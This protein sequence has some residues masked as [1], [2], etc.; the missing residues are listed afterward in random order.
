MLSYGS[1]EKYYQPLD[2][3]Q[4][5]GEGTYG[6][7]FRVVSHDGQPY[8]CKKLDMSSVPPRYRPSKMD[9]LENLLLMKNDY[10]CRYHHIFYD[11]EQNRALLVMDYFDRCCLA[12]IIVYYHAKGRQIPEDTIWRV[13]SHML[14]AL[15]YYHTPFKAGAPKVNRIVH[16]DV[17]PANIFLAGDGRARIVDSAAYRMLDKVTVTSTIFGTLGYTPPEALAMDQ[18][19]DKSDIWSLG[20]CIYAMC[21]KKPYAYNEDPQK[22]YDEIIQQPPVD[23]T[24]FGYSEDLNKALSYMLVTNPS[25][26]FCANDLMSYPTVKSASGPADPTWGLSF[27]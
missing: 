27:D 13:L 25:Q 19:T 3:T 16:R 11:S 6:D 5:I 18:Y 17:K 26:R 24:P 4:R 22:L 12:D 1:F 21:A 15:A 10:L 9:D 23:V 2:K 7:V 20:A 8:A 14:S